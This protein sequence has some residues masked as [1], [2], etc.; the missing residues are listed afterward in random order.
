M[1]Y[2]SWDQ[3]DWDYILEKVGLVKRK[4]GQ[5]I[6]YKQRECFDIVCAFDIETTKIHLPPTEDKPY[7]D[8][9]FM[10]IWQFQLGHECTII[11]RYWEEWEDMCK[12]IRDC[13]RDYADRHNMDDM[14]LLIWYDHNLS[15]EF[16]FI[17]GIYPF[18]ADEIFFRQMRKPIYCRM[19]DCIEIRCSY[20]LSNM[21]LDAFTKS[22]GCKTLKQSG[23]DFNYSIQRFPWSK[24]SE[25]EMLY[26][27]DDVISL[28]EAIERKMEK[29]GDTLLTIP[30]TSTGYV[31]R[32]L[33]EA[34][35][36]IRKRIENML[37][38]K[39]AYLMLRNAFRGGNTH[40]NRDYVGKIYDHV[41]S[42]DMSSCYPAQQLTR[43]F[44]MEKFKF[45]G[46]KI[47]LDRCL[48]YAMLGYAVVGRYQ[49]KNISLKNNHEPVP[50]L[51]FS[52]CDCLDAN[53]AKIRDPKNKNLEIDNGRVMAAYYLETTLTE[54]DLQI[55]LRQYH[56]SEIA[57]ID[58]M[59]ARKDYLPDCYRDVIRKYYTNKTSLKGAKTE[60][61]E[62]LY[63]KSK[64]LLNSV[65]GMSCSAVI[66]EHIDYYPDE[67][68]IRPMTPEEEEKALTKAPFSYAWGVYVTAWGRW[69]LQ[70]AIDRCYYIN[71]SGEK[72]STLI[73]CDTDSIKTI[74]PMDF[75]DLNTKLQRIATDQRATAD[76]PS[77]ETHY[78]GVFELDGKYDRFITQ[79]A[80]RYAFEK[81]N[82]KINP[83]TGERY[84][85][86]PLGRL[87]IV[88][89][90][91]THQVDE[92]TGIQYCIE[93]L[94]RLEN[95]KVGMRWVK[96][97]GTMALYNDDDDFLFH[98][99]D[100]QQIRAVHITKNV[101]LLDS[102]YEM[103]YSQDFENLIRQIEDYGGWKVRLWDE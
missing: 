74:R 44:P 32:D 85:K 97:G 101:T 23:Q 100:G 67:Y 34:C 69:A 57:V 62:Y 39:Q 14:P 7:N 59:V 19:Y 78:M 92:R 87:S 6:R 96:A 13:I 83:A 98:V 90:G 24:L 64:N 102:T 51:S 95:F 22:M 56:Y 75:T 12:T 54:L 9:S 5:R 63:F 4:Q 46:G 53:R 93:E 3:V 28:V 65:F 41:E 38:D 29:D 25:A 72:I 66:R 86:D 94:K 58:A 76:D 16:E 68:I 37:P 10:Y 43:K 8:H 15:F 79:G 48:N 31:R 61:E 89:S 70:N 84:D 103:G 81:P 33:K 55:V 80:K 50:Y 35:R 52:K 11:G 45:L 40:A 27:V 1:D 82:S 26:C 91:V 17:S 2:V 47:T 21:S 71:D 88:V 30:L 18:Q 36:P 42:Y 99:D 20:M 49:F 60:W 77:G 73:Y